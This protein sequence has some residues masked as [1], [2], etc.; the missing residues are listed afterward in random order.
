MPPIPRWLRRKSSFFGLTLAPI[1]LVTGTLVTLNQMDE[2]GRE[3]FA[4]GRGAVET[5]EHLA[6]ALRGRD[7]AAAGA[8][9]SPGFR[10]SPLGLAGFRQTGEKDGVETA[11]FAAR[12][13]EVGRDA[14]L[15]E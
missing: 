13:G 7:L 11:A 6:G 8:L 3:F 15:D 9:Y 12:P 10:G 1:V 4:T 5:L 2:N 14:A